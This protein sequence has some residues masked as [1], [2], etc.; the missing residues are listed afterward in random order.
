MK[1][2]THFRRNVF[3]KCLIIG[4]DFGEKCNR[5]GNRYSFFHI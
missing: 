5:T 2:G 3:F 1:E 4:K